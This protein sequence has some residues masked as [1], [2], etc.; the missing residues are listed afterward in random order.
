MELGIMKKNLKLVYSRGASIAN[1]RPKDYLLKFKLNFGS[2]FISKKEKIF[3]LKEELL[4]LYRDYEITTGYNE[5]PY[6]IRAEKK[7]RRIIRENKVNYYYNLFKK[8]NNKTY[9]IM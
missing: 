8:F 1:Q 6:F 9:N 5:E 7:I 3:T 4:N 2:I